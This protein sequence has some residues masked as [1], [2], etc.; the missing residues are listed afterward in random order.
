M[1]VI[2]CGGLSV[3]NIII[4]IV[5]EVDL[6][7]LNKSYC[8]FYVICSWVG[9]GWVLCV[10]KFGFGGDGFCC[11]DINYCNLDLC[12]F[13]NV[14]GVC[15]DGFGGWK[16]YLCDCK[17]GWLFFDCDVEINECCFDFCSVNGL[18]NCEDLINDFWCNCKLGYSGRFCEINI[19]D[20]ELGS[21]FY[22]G[23]CVDKVN[24]YICFCKDLYI[25]V[26]CDIDDSIC[27]ENLNIC[28]CNGICILYVE[29]L[30]KFFCWCE[31]FWGGNCLGCVLGYGG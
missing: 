29:D 6:C 18:E 17:F 30:L 15:W 1:F 16:N 28:F 14:I 20:C 21:C 3:V 2:D 12:Y 10:C 9:L 25:G 8:S 24:G 5:E 13:G 7:V 11:N 4:I 31:E 26:N 19:N 22:G 27:C 23:I